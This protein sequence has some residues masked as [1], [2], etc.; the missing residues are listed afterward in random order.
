[1]PQLELNED[2]K[3]KPNISINEKLSLP[4]GTN[5]MQVPCQKLRHI[6]QLMPNC[7]I[8]TP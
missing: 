6:N 5:D 4:S 3:K 7:I 1:M 2:E 8:V